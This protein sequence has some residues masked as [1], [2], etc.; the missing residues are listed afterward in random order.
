[1]KNIY[2]AYLITILRYSWFWLG[3]WAIYYSSFGGYYVIGLLETVM[4]VTCVLTEIP[5]GAIADLLGKKKTLVI[6]FFLSAIAS[7]WMG[8]APNVFNMALSLILLNIGGTLASG[9]FEALIYDS[10]KEEK[11][12]GLYNKVISNVTTLKMLSLGIFSIIGGY[13][14]LVDMRL[15]FHLN[16]IGLII[17][18]FLAF[19]VVEPKLDSVKLSIKTYLKQNIKGI[20]HLFRNIKVRN[21]VIPSLIVA[22]VILI[23]REGLDDILLLDYGFLDR[24]VELGYISAAYSFIA[25]F[26]TYFLPRIFEKV[27]QNRL[28]IVYL[29]LTT[30]TLLISPLVTLYFGLSVILIRIMIMPS[31]ENMISVKLNDNIESKYRATSLSA[32][33]MTQGLPYAL[34][35]FAITYITDIIPSQYIAVIMGLVLLGMSVYLTKTIKR[36]RL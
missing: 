30:L 4:I 35:I 26:S 5:T 32:F 17:A 7:F 12:E 21:I 9:S 29:V 15:P 11:K 8:F 33:S 18:M 20:N 3:T 22:S 16:G 14:S 10:L 19:F 36:K 25:A 1:M 27:D 2:L 6:S 28:Y 24:Q 34:T 31:I 23:L 13:I